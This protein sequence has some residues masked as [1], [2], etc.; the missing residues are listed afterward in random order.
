[1]FTLIQL[2]SFVAVAEELHFGAAAERLNMT[3]P[4]LS[5]QIQLLEREL[6]SQLFDRTSRKVE[7]TDAGRTLLP[8]ARQ[9]L[10]MAIKTELDVR[11]V[12]LG[13]A[14]AV[15]VGYTAIAGQSA[16]PKLLRRAADEQ[17]GVS[18]IL[19]ELVSTDQMDGLVK[20]AVD[21]GLLRPI[22]ARP[23]IV[24]RPLMR[25][26]LVIALPADSDLAGDGGPVAL[27]ALDGRPLMMYST[28]E[29]RYFHDLVLRLFASAGAHANITQYASQVPA[30]L[31]FVEA[32][33]GL[34]LV[35]AS[36]QGLAP[37][38]VQFRE[39]EPSRG[40]KDLNRVDLEVAWNEN[41]TNPAVRRL[42]D[43]LDTPPEDEGPA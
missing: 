38:G 19:R 22:V 28:A 26:R 13:E 29:A 23:G 36:A 8:S 12:S 1:M 31:A 21:I 2:E 18:L 30:L 6:G 15:T 37:S 34:T 35:P 4:P 32:G 25:D 7:L 27:R 14:G 41:N 42:L 16:L 24:S 43:L 39:L 20:G 10:D 3:Q 40:I 9:I 5:R 11:R 33:L 17:P